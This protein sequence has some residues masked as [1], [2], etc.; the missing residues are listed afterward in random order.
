MLKGESWRC[1]GPGSRTASKSTLVVGLFP[2][3]LAVPRPVGVLA[4]ARTNFAPSRGQH[5][6][7]GLALST[8]LP[9]DGRQLPL[10]G[11]AEVGPFALGEC[12]VILGWIFAVEML[13][14]MTH[15]QLPFQ[16]CSARQRIALPWCL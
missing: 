8:S 12:S 3:L 7:K 9:G 11:A 10:Q 5:K 15:L 2:S 16:H 6:F 14:I 13:H 4:G 1:F